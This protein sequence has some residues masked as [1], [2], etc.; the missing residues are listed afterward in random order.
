M[1]EWRAGRGEERRNWWRGGSWRR[2]T[3]PA[4]LFASV[5]LC[6]AAGLLSHAGSQSPPSLPLGHGRSFAGAAESAGG[7]PYRQGDLAGKEQLGAGQGQHCDGL[8]PDRVKAGLEACVSHL[9]P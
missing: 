4:A 6:C 3:A 2:S 8:Q 9:R 7:A 5:T 1:I